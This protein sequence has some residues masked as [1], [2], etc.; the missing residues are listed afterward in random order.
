MTLAPLLNAPPAVQIHALVALSL[1]PLTALQ[2]YRRKSGLY[3]R[4]IGWAWAVLMAV[5]AASSFWLHGFKVMGPFSPIHILSVITLVNLVL[6][7]RARR[8]NRIG[9]HR[10]Y[11]MGIA[12]GWAAAGAFTLLPGRLMLQVVTG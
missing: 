2:F 3:H 6:G 9:A 4:I 12:L 1:I 8:Q 7:I 5:T 11:M 10:K